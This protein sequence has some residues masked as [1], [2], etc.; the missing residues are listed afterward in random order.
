MGM[1]TWDKVTLTWDCYGMGISTSVCLDGKFKPDAIDPH[2]SNYKAEEQVHGLFNMQITSLPYE[3]NNGQRKGEII[4]DIRR[5]RGPNVAPN[6]KALVKLLEARLNNP[7]PRQQ[8]PNEF[9]I[10]IQPPA[11]ESWADTRFTLNFVLANSEQFCDTAIEI[12][13]GIFEALGIHDER[14]LS[15]SRFTL[16]RESFVRIDDSWIT[17]THWLRMSHRLPIWGPEDRQ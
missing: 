12:G 6:S 13:R 1:K 2:V 15:L 11:T 7:P 4:L 8:K 17:F 3:W 14:G 9:G 10:R 5:K 16:R